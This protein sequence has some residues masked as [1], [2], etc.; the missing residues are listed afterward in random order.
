MQVFE[1]L[2]NHDVAIRRTRR[3]GDGQG[4]WVVDYVTVTPVRG[5]LRPASS[6][7]REAA[8]LE[9]RQISHVLYVRAGTD[10]SRGDE[11]TVDGLVVEVLGIREPSKAGQHL[12]IDALEIQKE[13][14]A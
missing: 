1:S 8:L 3:T 10:I 7:E 14:A 5:R 2:L 6:A 11:V 13:V 4:G 9:A 12:Q